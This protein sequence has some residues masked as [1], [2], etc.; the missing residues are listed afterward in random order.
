MKMYDDE[1]DPFKKGLTERA[2]TKRDAA[3][4]E[5]HARRIR[6]SPSGMDPQEVVESFPKVCLQFFSQWKKELESCWK[7]LNPWTPITSGIT[8]VDI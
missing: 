8:W 5:E 3:R 7:R 4:A 6:D 2:K 1:V